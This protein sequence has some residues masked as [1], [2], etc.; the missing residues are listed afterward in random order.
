MSSV[1]GKSMSMFLQVPTYKMVI[2]PSH[3]NEIVKCPITVA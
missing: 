2:L 3:S 1:F